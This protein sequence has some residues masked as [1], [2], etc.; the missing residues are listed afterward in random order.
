M[1]REA[2]TVGLE[3]LPDRVPLPSLC[4]V[5]DLVVETD[6]RFCRRRN[7]GRRILGFTRGDPGRDEGSNSEENEGEGPL[8]AS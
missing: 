6:R 1:L 4:E 5:S 3:S 7:L 8:G 2:G